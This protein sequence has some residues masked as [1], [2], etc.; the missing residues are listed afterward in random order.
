MV[1][2]GSFFFLP[3]SYSSPHVYVLVNIQYPVLARSRDVAVGKLV[4]C[5]KSLIGGRTKG[6]TKMSRRPLPTVYKPNFRSVSEE[7]CILEV[8]Y[9]VSV[10]VCPF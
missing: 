10:C 8:E 4:V 6:L 9:E 5:N 7:Q 2:V 3:T 1:S